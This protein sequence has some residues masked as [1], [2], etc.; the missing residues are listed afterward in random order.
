[1]ISIRSTNVLFKLVKEGFMSFELD[2]NNVDS[3]LKLILTEDITYIKESI[4]EAFQCG[5]ITTYDNNLVEDNFIKPTLKLITLNLE[6]ILSDN[7]LK[8]YEDY[9]KIKNWYNKHK[10]EVMR[11]SNVALFLSALDFNGYTAIK[12]DIIGYL[13]EIKKYIEDIESSPQ[14]K[15]DFFSISFDKLWGCLETI[16]DN[17]GY[18][19]EYFHFKH[20]YDSAK[21]NNFNIFSTIKRNDQ[22]PCGSG[23]K[24][25]KCCI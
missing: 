19:K 23:K 12:K 20:F 14:Y 11:T 17:Y 9:D 3:K 24:F 6:K 7:I 18:A 25:K 10:I 21:E 4:I 5:Y 15:F 22:C 8:G 2:I 13:E 16:P 1:M